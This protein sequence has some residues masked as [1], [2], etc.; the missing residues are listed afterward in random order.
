[1]KIPED[2]KMS[3]KIREGIKTRIKIQEDVQIHTMTAEVVVNVMKNANTNNPLTIQDGSANHTMNEEANEITSIFL[4]MEDATH[5][6]R[7]GNVT[8]IFPQTDRVTHGNDATVK[9]ER[10]LSM[11]RPPRRISH[12]HRVVAHTDK[13]VI[14]LAAVI[15][16]MTDS[17]VIA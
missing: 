1:M 16:I 15:T 11:T 3:T 14:P 7:T 17:P 12:P 6:L 4:T 10:C 13:N 9:T 8:R 2:N 5:G